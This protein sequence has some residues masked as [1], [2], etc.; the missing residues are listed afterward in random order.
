MRGTVFPGRGGS[1]CTPPDATGCLHGLLAP[2]RALVLVWP[3]DLA[4]VPVLE[5][6][7]RGTKEPSG[8]WLR[9]WFR[10]RVSW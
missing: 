1:D 6:T 7:E 5:G 3:L 9:G 4:L 8:G 10:E 2:A